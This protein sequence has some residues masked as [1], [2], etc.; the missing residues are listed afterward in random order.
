MS[1]INKRW[2]LQGH[3]YPFIFSNGAGFSA[4][5]RLFVLGGAGGV[6]VADRRIYTCEVLGDGSTSAWV[7]AGD[8]PVAANFNAC[9]YH[10]GSQTVYHY[11][12]ST[13]GN[14]KLYAAPVSGGVVGPFRTVS[15]WHAS[16]NSSPSLVIVGD[17]IYVVGGSLGRCDSFRI[18]TDG[19]PQSLPKILNTG[20]VA[21]DARY[22]AFAFTS[23]GYMYLAG[24]LN[25]QAPFDR[26]EV[27]SAPLQ[28]NGGLGAWKKV[29]NLPIAMG[30]CGGAVKGDKLVI[31]GGRF[32]GTTSTNRVFSA[33]LL[34]GGDIG[35][36]TDED[37][38]PIAFRGS[39]GTTL[40]VGNK[41][42]VVGGF[43]T[44]NVDT[45]YSSEL[46]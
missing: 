8:L 28:P 2:V 30:R 25:S 23:N 11:G 36:F 24:G 12:G 31:L 6:G 21:A 40:T 17:W 32:G 43:T 15:T 3:R 1:V 33:S 5:N 10:E 38:F 22:A 37:A 9:V 20:V 7:K 46:K 39:G 29:G 16:I 42:F 19:V 44:A 45:V 41:I 34:P 4:G 14:N 26:S 35:A 13:A 27:F 18:G